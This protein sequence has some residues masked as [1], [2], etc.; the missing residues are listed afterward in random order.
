MGKET[1]PPPP[2]LR[3]MFVKEIFWWTIT[4]SES[5]LLAWNETTNKSRRC[6]DDD[7]G[8]SGKSVGEGGRPTQTV[9]LRK[10]GAAA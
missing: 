8:E 10:V 4:M 1:P 9:S 5:K 2:N 7:K 3:L 6:R